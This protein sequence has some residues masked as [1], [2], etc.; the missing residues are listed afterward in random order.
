MNALSPV[1]SCFRPHCAWLLLPR[2]GPRGSPASARQAFPFLCLQHR[3]ALSELLRRQVKTML[4]ESASAV[5]TELLLRSVCQALCH[6]SCL[7]LSEEGVYILSRCRRWG[8]GG[9]V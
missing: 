2:P 4:S 8:Q 3:P 6:C 7:T 1:S 5:A 9:D